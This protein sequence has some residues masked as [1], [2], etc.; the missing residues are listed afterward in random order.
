MKWDRYK[1]LGSNKGGSKDNMVCKEHY[2]IIL[3]LINYQ[4]MYDYINY[5]SEKQWLIVIIKYSRSSSD[6]ARGF[7]D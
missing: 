3:G 5:M 1:A 2:L 6:H 7:I 4:S